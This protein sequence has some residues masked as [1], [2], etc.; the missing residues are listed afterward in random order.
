VGEQSDAR[1]NIMK[2]KEIL[3]NEDGS[4]LV[5]ALI[6]MV[7]LTL[8][9]LSTNRTAS[10][11]IQI[12]GNEMIFKRNLFTAEAAAMEAMQRLEEVDSLVET[13]TDFLIPEG[14]NVTDDDIRNPDSWENNFPGG[15]EAG[16]SATLDGGGNVQ[17]VAVSMGIE[18]G[19][20]LG[21]GGS[22]IY[23]YKVFGRSNQNNGE[24]I[25][26]MGYR[27]SQ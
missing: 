10:I 25:I 4:V 24:S 21:L 8:V 5:I 14:V 22:R 19:S 17:Y 1:E 13:P 11:E 12:A 6:F 2:E 27:K 9:G 20:G 18:P 26:L 16:V 15:K 7:L 23:S 3:K